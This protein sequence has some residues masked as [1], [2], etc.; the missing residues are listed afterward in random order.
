MCSCLRRHVRSDDEIL[1]STLQPARHSCRRPDELFS[2]T[3]GM[4]KCGNPYRHNNFA[5]YLRFYI[6]CAN[7]QHTTDR[8]LRKSAE[9][10]MQGRN[11][12]SFPFSMRGGTTTNI[13][14][15]LYCV[16]VWVTWRSIEQA[17]SPIF[18]TRC[19]FRRSPLRMEL[20]SVGGIRY[21]TSS[22]SRIP[23]GWKSALEH[24]RF[25]R[26]QPPPGGAVPSARKMR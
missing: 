22:Q 13:V 18:P 17:S 26:S 8:V 5:N 24:C 6:G 25:R 4:L 15:L 20:R 1:S 7:L 19:L 10:G 9:Q 21:A 23:H 2:E 11:S 16:G 14:I 3:P 12:N